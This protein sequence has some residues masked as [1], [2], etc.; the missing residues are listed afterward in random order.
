VSV[1]KVVIIV[2]YWA[3]TPFNVLHKYQHLGAI[4]CLNFEKKMTGTE[5]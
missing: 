3:A 1:I 2:I 5:A 4:G